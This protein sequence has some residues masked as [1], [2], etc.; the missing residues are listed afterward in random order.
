MSASR[1]PLP[2]T[3]TTH[4]SRTAIAL[5]SSVGGIAITEPSSQVC[6]ATGAGA[7]GG[8]AISTRAGGTIG[9]AAPKWKA[10][11]MSALCER[12]LPSLRKVDADV[13]PPV[14]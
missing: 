13:D 3:P 6:I 12:N 7:G 9:A 1:W 10:S 4:H 5:I 8:G 14:P 2:L 11:P